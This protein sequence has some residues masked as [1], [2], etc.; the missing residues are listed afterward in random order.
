MAD[1]EIPFHP[2]RKQM[3][4]YHLGKVKCVGKITL[5]FQNGCRSIDNTEIIIVRNTKRVEEKKNV[6]INY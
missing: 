6:T 5:N 1:I 2:Q 3:I 4:T